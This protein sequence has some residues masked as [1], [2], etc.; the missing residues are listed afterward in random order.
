MRGSDP[1]PYLPCMKIR[2]YLTLLCPSAVQ[3]LEPMAL[4]STKRDLGRWVVTP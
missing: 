1:Q 2:A 3:T 4:A